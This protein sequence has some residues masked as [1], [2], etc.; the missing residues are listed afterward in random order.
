MKLVSQKGQAMLELGLMLP[1]LILIF[2]PLVDIGRLFYFG[3][4]L[5]QAV[6]AGTQYGMSQ[7][8]GGS[9]VTTFATIA[10]QMTAATVAAG[11]NIGLATGDVTTVDRYWRCGTSSSTST[12]FTNITGQCPG[13]TTNVY[14]R[15]I[16]TKAMDTV[17][18]FEWAGG[19]AWSVTRS[20]QIRVQ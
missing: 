14:V 3:M 19:S 2:M 16:A 12:D 10:S 8:I 5:T 9:D 6:R 20:A 11:S 4:T 1:V 17:F 7:D 18:P 13:D 15:V